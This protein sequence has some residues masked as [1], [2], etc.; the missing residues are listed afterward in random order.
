MMVAGAESA[1]DGPP[2]HDMPAVVFDLGGVLLDWN[3]R[4]VLAAHVADD[5]TADMLMERLDID[6]V[7]HA[8]DVGVPVTDVRARWSRDHPEDQRIVDDYL[9]RWQDTIAG[10]LDGV[11]DILADLRRQGV[12]LYALSNFSGELFRRI[13]GRFAFLGWFDGLLISG[14]EGM[15]K[16]D[17]RIYALLLER[18][19]LRPAATVF[20]DDHADNVAA[21]RDAGLVGIWYT[22]PSQLR[23][24]LRVLGLG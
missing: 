5:V 15:L 7:Q 2:G 19:G 4:Y 13:R 18:Y 11:V 23:R 10:P 17:A 8:L 1:T 14:D 6:G 12:R 22:S 21:A 9:D 24:D 20:V 3:P 16:P